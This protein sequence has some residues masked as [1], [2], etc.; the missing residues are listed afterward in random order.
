MFL[1]RSRDAEKFYRR[2]VQ[3]S[4][5][6]PGAHMNLGAMLHSNGKWEEAEASYLRALQ[7]RPNDKVA[8]DNLEKVRNLMKNTREAALKANEPEEP[9]KKKKKKKKKDKDKDKDKK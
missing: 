6:D 1:G 2:A 3:I 5:D 4:P 7:L 8:E 9:E